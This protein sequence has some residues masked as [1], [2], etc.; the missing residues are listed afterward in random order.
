MHGMGTSHLHIAF[1]EEGS[2]LL[3]VPGLGIFA[4]LRAS[5]QHV[6]S[7]QRPAPAQIA[8]YRRTQLGL[9]AGNVR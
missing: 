6:H 5:M 4:V 9:C 1:I 8:M 3:A 7:M 2:E